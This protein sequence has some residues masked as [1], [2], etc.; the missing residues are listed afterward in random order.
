MPSPFPGAARRPSADNDTD[1][2]PK[3]SP[4]ITNTQD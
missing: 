1:M 4:R 2:D 3:C